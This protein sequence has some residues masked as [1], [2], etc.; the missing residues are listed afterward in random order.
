MY[1]DSLRVIDFVWR[2][3]IEIKKSHTRGQNFVA[4]KAEYDRTSIWT[5]DKYFRDEITF[6]DEITTRQLLP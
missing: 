4:L 6:N 5:T 1:I 2:R 3:N